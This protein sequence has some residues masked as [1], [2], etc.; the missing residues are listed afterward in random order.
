[1]SRRP[2]PLRCHSLESRIA[3]AVINFTINSTT[4]SLTFGGSVGGST[5]VQQGAGSLT[6]K[7]SGTSQVNVDFANNTIQAVS[8]GSLATALNSG[9]WAP[10]VGGTAGTSAANY[11]GRVTVTIGFPV[12]VN[13]A[14]RGA[15]ST[16]DSGVLAMTGT[17][18]TRT[19]PSTQTFTL[20]AGSVDYR[21]AL[22]GTL[23]SGTGSIAGSTAVNASATAG[24]F[25]DLGSGNY[26]ITTPVDVT[27]NTTVNAPSGPLPAIYTLKGSMIGSA[28]LPVV[29]LNGAGT[30]N[31]VTFI[32]NG[33]PP[34]LIAPAATIT[35]NPSASMTGMTVTL[36]A[37]PDG[38]AESLAVDLTGTGLTS[39]GYDSLTG[40]LTISGA[41]TLATYQSVLQKVTYADAAGSPTAGPRTVT[42]SV[43]DAG[44]ESL[45]R[46]ASGTV[47]AS[48]ARVSSVT[49][50]DGATQ[51]SMVRSVTVAFDK[52]V[53]ANGSPASFITLTGP[54]GPVALAVDSSGST[55]TQSI[56]R[57]TFSGAGITNGSL[58]NGRYTLN[59]PADNGTAGIVN[60]DGD[61]NGS[62]GGDFTLVGDP[63]TNKLFRLFGDSDGDG[64]VGTSDFLAFRLAFLS[65]GNPTFDLDGNG[66]VD[67]ADFLAFRL[68]F[69]Q[70]I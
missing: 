17:G 37:P 14:I 69:L 34:V 29:D 55:P 41:G 32:S 31:D 45:V 27:I 9:N 59:I 50:N 42:V 35:R 30:G 70:S 61:G 38:A 60:F 57:L 11:G 51:R 19:F 20:T 63:A 67:T 7:Y 64:T 53:T 62:A 25:S 2:T 18:S 68:S 1:M 39:T 36:V 54:G 15:E 16:L 21:D 23:A 28:T 33:L 65:A 58:S 52:V 48:A 12:N 13:L 8:A 43:S 49:V 6:T 56:Y 26:S 66:T 10:N 3:P 5:I 40:K 4:S 22:T 44:N 24:Q 46:T 47:V